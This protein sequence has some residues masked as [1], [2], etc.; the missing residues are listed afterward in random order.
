MKRHG[1]QKGF[2]LIELLVVIS[3]IGLLSSVAMTGIV[4]ARK[5][6]NNSKKMADFKSVSNALQV[7]HANYNRMPYN[8]NPGSGACEGGGYYEQSMQE[9]VNAG[10]LRAVP[11][12]PD[13]SKYCYYNYGA[14]N[15]IG[16]ILVT[17]LVGNPATTVG[18]GASCRPFG[19]NWCSNINA[20][21]QYCIC[22]PY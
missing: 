6:A 15:S 11:T 19:N 7:F 4:S 14:N 18:V 20:S 13:A 1:S 3:I 22:N 2:T 17:S 12:S 16:A 8:Y 21:T 9:L 10:L 5:K